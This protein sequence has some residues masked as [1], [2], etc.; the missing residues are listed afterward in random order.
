MKDYLRYLY[1]LYLDYMKLA[2]S[3]LVLSAILLSLH[4][5]IATSN[6]SLGI[7]VLV[8]V[9]LG[10]VLF[11]TL[12]WRRHV[13]V[14]KEQ[15]QQKLR[16]LQRRGDEALAQRAEKR[17]DE[18]RHYLKFMRT[19]GIKD[20]RS[21]SEESSLLNDMALLIERLQVQH[22]RQSSIEDALDRFLTVLD[23][24]GVGLPPDARRRILNSIVSDILVYEHAQKQESQRFIS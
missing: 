20:Y 9:F 5:L 23:E 21:P 12:T 2:L 15:N 14:Q 11:A 22:V 16:E 8:V 10:I 4:S 24:N 1:D 6:L 17:M 13:A 19:R 3:G 7:V 18:A